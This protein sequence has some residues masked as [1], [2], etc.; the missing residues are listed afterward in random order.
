M[1]TGSAR[2]GAGSLEIRVLGEF[3][4]LRNGENVGLPPSRKTR[5]LLAY[6]AVVDRSQ[7][8]ERLCR[9]FWDLPDDP[10]GALR[11]SLSK[12]R[13]IVNVE[14]GDALVTDR[15][16]VALRSEPIALDL[17]QV[18]S[19]MAREPATIETSELEQA[20]CLF[21]GGF[22]EDLSLPNCPEFEAWR[23]SQINDVDLLRAR[24]LRTLVAR[25]DGDPTRALPYAHALLAMSPADEQLAAAIRA[26]AEKARAQAMQMPLKPSP[27]D[28]ELPVPEAA[29]STSGVQPS[30][31][32]AEAERKH[33]TMITIEI[34]SPLH[35]FV[36]ID[37]ELVMQQVDPLFEATLAI[38]EQSGGTISSSGDSRITAIFG[39]T[40]SNEHHAVAA[41]RAALLVKSTIERQ[42]QG[43]ASVRAGLD[44]GEVMIRRRRRGEAERIEVTGVAVRCAARLAQSLRRGALAATDRTRA[45]VAGMVDMLRLPRSDIPRFDRDEQAY[46]LRAPV[47]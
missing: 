35:A 26:L 19:L 7:Q 17:R 6:L 18:Q 29:A 38:V 11:W 45:A 31:A 37:P 34:I 15:N 3:A 20:A 30:A 44:T 14:G 1:S 8:R 12:V 16:T 41:C 32:D 39:A 36:S 46:E 9:M 42:S 10:R 28:A 13:Q 40:A 27:I 47:E 5:A 21:Q 43:T 33:V 22:L 24:I 2:T 4:V 23:T 25:L